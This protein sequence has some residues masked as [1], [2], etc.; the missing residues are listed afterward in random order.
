MYRGM[1]M[2]QALGLRRDCPGARSAPG[3]F[4]GQALGRRRKSMEIHDLGE[5]C[6]CSEAEEGAKVGK[7][8]ISTRYKC[9]LF[10]LGPRD[11]PTT[12]FSHF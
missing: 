2:R 9:F 5:T 11:F 6:T 4:E 3:K 1:P 10:F 7:F 8:Q 12:R